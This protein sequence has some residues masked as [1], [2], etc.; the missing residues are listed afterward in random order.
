MGYSMKYYVCS[1]SAQ[2]ILGEQKYIPVFFN[3]SSK[4]I[5]YRADHNFVATTLARQGI[6]I[7]NPSKELLMMLALKCELCEAVTPVIFTRY[8][9]SII[10]DKSRWLSIND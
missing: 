3:L 1:I 2:E 9:C 10:S 5:G 8:L 6:L 4:E 7:I